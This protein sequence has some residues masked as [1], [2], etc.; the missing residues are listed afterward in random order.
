MES[1]QPTSQ[2]RKHHD[3]DYEKERNRVKVHERSRQWATVE[4]DDEENGEKTQGKTVEKADR[5]S[6]DS[7]SSSSDES[8]KKKSKKSSS[9]KHSDKKKDKKSKKEKK[10]KKHKKEKK[11]KR[12]HSESDDHQSTKG[13]AIDQNEF[14]KYGIIREENFF[15]KQREFEV[16]NVH[17]F[18]NYL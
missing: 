9:K 18:R 12:K 15:A 17:R 5:S 14:G 10:H 8:E 7:S 11:S 13:G 1:V 4:S 3:E 2:K 6:S 16:C